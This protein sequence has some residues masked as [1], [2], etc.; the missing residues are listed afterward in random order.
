[1]YM[2]AVEVNSLTLSGLKF[3]S[4]TAFVFPVLLHLS[5]SNPLLLFGL[6]VVPPETT[7]G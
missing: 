7:G 2:C 1:M 4:L 6:I 5:L 3:F